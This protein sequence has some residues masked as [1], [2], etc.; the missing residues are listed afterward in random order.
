MNHR[1]SLEKGS[2]KFTCPKCGDKRSFKRYIDTVNGKYL[3]DDIGRCDHESK[4]KYHKPP[5]DAGIQY[6]PSNADLPRKM[7]KKEP[8]YIQ[9]ELFKSTLKSYDK[10][11]FIKGLLNV[12]DRGKVTDL[13]KHYYIGTI[14]DKVVFWQIDQYLRIRTGK[15]MSYNPTT[16]KRNK[17]YIN[18]AHS[19]YRLKDY[20]SKPC[21]YGLHLIRDLD[22]GIPICIVEAEKTAIIMS[23]YYPDVIWMAAG[24]I[25]F[26]NKEK[27]L[28]LT[29]HT[30]YLYPD[31]G[32]EIV[33]AKKTKG[34]PNI[35]LVDWAEALGIQKE[36]YNGADLADF[37]H[38]TSRIP[39]P[40]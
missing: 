33:W 5:K 3:G 29:K 39:L 17:D 16:L 14:S 24:G 26:L 25:Q 27:L 28:P 9:L 10:N 18:W 2:R 30:M 4:C 8:S 36:D 35:K 32:A 7:G 13:V 20:N 22:P 37:T 31:I 12:F 19:F 23:G 11:S 40:K 34:I 1:Y 21:L 38:P 15:I 6:D